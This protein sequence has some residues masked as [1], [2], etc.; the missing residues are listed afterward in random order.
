MKE[1]D[2]IKAMKEGR[3]LPVNMQVSKLPNQP[4]TFQAT[5][6]M[7]AKAT[8]IKCIDC[9]NDIFVPAFKQVFFSIITSPTGK[10]EFAS[11]NIGLICSK[12]GRS[13]NP[14]EWLYNRNKKLMGEDE[15]GS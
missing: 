5:P 13:Y 9:N 11:Q 10:E 14:K 6:E 15:D 3:N 1:N 4:R 7:M 2:I 8:E 12:C